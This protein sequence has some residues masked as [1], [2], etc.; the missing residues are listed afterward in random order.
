MRTTRPLLFFALTLAFATAL[1]HA[2]ITLAPLFRDHAVLQRDKPLPVWGRADAGEHVTVTF[3]GQTVTTIASTNPADAGSWIVYLPPV[4]ASA[5]PAE[6][7]VTGTNPARP[8]HI[9]DILTGDVWLASGQSNMERRVN[10]FQNAAEEIAAANNPL[11]RVIT[12]NRHESDTPATDVETTGWLLTTPQTVADFSATAYYFARELQPRIGVPLGIVSSSWGG[13]KIEAWISANTLATNPAFAPVAQRWQ[14]TLDAYHVAQTAKSAGATQSRPIQNPKSSRATATVRQIQNSIGP[15][16][17][18][19]PSGLF[20]GMINPLLPFALRGVIW[21]QGESNTGRSNEYHALFA[22]MITQWRAN[23]GQ[24]DIPFFWVQLADYKGGGA[25]HTDWAFLREAQT[26]TL[27]LP[28]T[29]QAVT[30]D[31]GDRND[32]HPKNKQE[33]GRRLALIARA[34][35]YGATVDYLGP[36]FA[37]AKREGTAMRVTFR[38][39]GTDGLTSG[40]K[41]PQSFELAG[42]DKIFHPATATINPADNTILVTSPAVPA[43]VAVRYA[44]RNSPGANLFNSAGLPAVPFR[45][46][47]WA[48]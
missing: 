4:A 32:I 48:Q 34:K 35:V 17:Q 36:T 14:K 12:I 43:P 16:H 6:L 18:D 47:D 27:S 38:A 9:T 8:V 13:T 20:N 44:W 41:P 3:R 25:D 1:A 37:T 30:I 5:Q 46:D 45:S 24:G 40:N 29:G 33:V 15:G 7:T 22:A 11:I 23:F 26:Q 21:Y 28:A 2:D 19:T 31:I 10:Q 42:A 39:A